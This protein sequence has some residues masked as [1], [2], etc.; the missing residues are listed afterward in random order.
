ML[1]ARGVIS[2]LLVVACQLSPSAT[3]SIPIESPALSPKGETQRA[4]VTEVTDG[5]TIHVV[6]DGA[7]FRVRYI[8]IDAPEI[9]HDPTLVSHWARQRRR[10][11]R[12]WSWG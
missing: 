10:P 5:D 11:T 1:P 12:I 7:E 9:A 6:I 2:A 3:N 8:G 4:I